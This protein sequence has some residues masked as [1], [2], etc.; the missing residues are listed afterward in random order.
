[1]RKQKLT[2]I[3]VQLL[4]STLVLMAEANTRGFDYKKNVVKSTETKDLELE[5]S[6]E[7]EDFPD[8]ITFA[9]HLY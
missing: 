3:L 6:Q 2:L 9:L 1:M 4:A 5:A 8:L 7:T